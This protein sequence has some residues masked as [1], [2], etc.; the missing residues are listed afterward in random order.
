MI[1]SKEIFNKNTRDYIKPD[2]SRN[3]IK[4]TILWHLYSKRSAFAGFETTIMPTQ[5]L[6]PNVI[7]LSMEEYLHVLLI[8]GITHFIVLKRENHLRRCISAQLAREKQM[9]HSRK[10][11]NEVTS[12][13]LD[14]QNTQI[15]QGWMP[16]KEVFK[17][18]DERYEFLYS[19]LK[20]HQTLRLGYE[21]DIRENPKVA[22]EKVCD[23]IEIDRVP[24]ETDYKMT[25]PFPLYQVLSNFDEVA[26]HLKGTPY[27]WMLTD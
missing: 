14:I 1:W 16:L 24:V 19:L 23:F 8:S 6:G 22:Y 3:P 21:A 5:Q 25:N 17:Q 20:P 26:A 2:W 7:G 11:V 27:E 18:T 13:H 10:P 12:L 4:K 15:G 9:Y